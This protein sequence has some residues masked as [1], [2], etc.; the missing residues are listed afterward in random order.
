MTPKTWMKLIETAFDACK[1]YDLECLVEDYYNEFEDNE[2][3]V[4]M[5]DNFLG[6]PMVANALPYNF[7]FQPGY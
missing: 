2:R 7:P 1:W 3:A 6:D 4:E 5:L